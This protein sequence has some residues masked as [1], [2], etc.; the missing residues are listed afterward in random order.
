M[1]LL[2]KSSD[3]GGHTQCLAVMGRLALGAVNVPSSANDLAMIAPDESPRVMYAPASRCM[4]KPLIALWVHLHVSRHCAAPLLRQSSRFCM[5][6][7]C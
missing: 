5:Y 3:G 6:G 4:S 1:R 2:V 7:R